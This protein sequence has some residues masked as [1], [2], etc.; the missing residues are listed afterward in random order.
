MAKKGNKG[1]IGACYEEGVGG[2]KKD[3]A[4]AVSIYKDGARE[5]DAASFH[6]LACH[7]EE[8][9]TN[10]SKVI[11]ATLF[12]NA[13]RLGFSASFSKLAK[14]Y[15][16][17]DGVERDEQ[18]AVFLLD[19]ASLKGDTSAMCDFAE[20]YYKGTGVVADITMAIQLNRNAA[21]VGE[22]RAI[23]ARARLEESALN[24]LQKEVSE[25]VGP[26][27]ALLK[28]GRRPQNK[29]ASFFRNLLPKERQLKKNFEE[30][31]SFWDGYNKK[32]KLDKRGL[33]SVVDQYLDLDGKRQFEEKHRKSIEELMNPMVQMQ[34]LIAS[35]GDE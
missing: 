35:D 16:T 24:E 12:R 33:K 20:C 21:D 3:L 6:F 2:Y 30:F 28:Q 11:A 34:M 18:M 32:F 26:V 19:E 15:L 29:F 5:H 17:G 25:K 9:G 31:V 1:A 27:V 8:E 13:A 22:Q 14:A 23:V 4:E 10:K 7:F